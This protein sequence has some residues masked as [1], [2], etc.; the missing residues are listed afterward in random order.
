MAYL[1][2]L[3]ILVLGLAIAASAG[4]VDLTGDTFDEAV[5]GSGKNA[6]V[7]FYAPWWVSNV[8]PNSVE[9]GVDNRISSCRV[10]VSG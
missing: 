5:L 9:A 4:S 7:K 1:K 3:P 10:L 8:Q 6:F 2:A